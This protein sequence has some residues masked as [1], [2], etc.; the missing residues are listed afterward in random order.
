MK[1]LSNTW[2]GYT[3]LKWTKAEAVCYFLR[4]MAE[5]TKIAHPFFEERLRRAKHQ[6]VMRYFDSEK[7][8]FNF[9]GAKIPDISHDPEKLDVLR[10]VY[11]MARTIT[12]ISLKSSIKAW[13]K[14]HTDIPTEFLMLP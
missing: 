3:R 13:S 4:R 10:H 7:R 11:I 5:K 2:N 8:C 12:G 6:S 14:A 9:N 1:L